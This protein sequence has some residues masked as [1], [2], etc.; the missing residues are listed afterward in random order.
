[1]KDVKVEVKI[2][3]LMHR[4]K[5]AMPQ[6]QALTYMYIEVLGRK[7][8]RILT[9]ISATTEYKSKVNCDI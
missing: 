4:T 1:M 7:L 5:Y 6:P 8:V 3:E 9:V 2:C